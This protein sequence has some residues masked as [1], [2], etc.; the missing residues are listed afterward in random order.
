[1]EMVGFDD[2]MALFHTSQIL[3]GK[4]VFFDLSFLFAVAELEFFSVRM[5]LG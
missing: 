3:D 4:T 5:N 1:M 2:R